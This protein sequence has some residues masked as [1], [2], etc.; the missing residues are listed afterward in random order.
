M[1]AICL[2]KIRIIILSDGNLTDHFNHHN[3]S[4][5]HQSLHHEWAQ[6][7]EEE[8]RRLIFQ[9]TLLF[10]WQ[11]FSGTFLQKQQTCVIYEACIGACLWC[12][13][14]VLQFMQLLLI[15]LQLQQAT[16]LNCL[17]FIMTMFLFKFSKTSEDM[18][19]P[20]F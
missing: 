6:C 14:F 8:Q 1:F 18:W 17:M 9:K 16:K 12:M 10:A 2:K 20:P 3:R 4:S 11:S 5:D 19:G 7:K 15:D 13:F